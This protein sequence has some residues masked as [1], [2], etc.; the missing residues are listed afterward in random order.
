MRSWILIGLLLVACSS[1]TPA[2]V[3]TQV[4][5]ATPTTIMASTPTVQP[6]N[7][8]LVRRPNAYYEY[9]PST[10]SLARVSDTVAQPVARTI[11][12]A[13]VVA[14]HAHTML[15]IRTQDDTTI[16]V[17]ATTSQQFGPFDACDS[18]TWAPDNAALWCMRFGHIYQIDP[19]AQTD[20]LHIVAT[21]DTY[22]VAL[23]QHPLTN[24]HWMS[25]VRNATTQLCRFDAPHQT[26]T[27]GCIDTG[28]LPRWSPDGQLIASIVDRRIVITD[29]N[30]QHIASAGLGDIG[31]IQITW[32]DDTQLALN[33]RTQR[34]RYQINDARISV[35][36]SETIIVG[37]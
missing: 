17:D 3:D 8:P 19:A 37:R 4:E 21:G 27:T 7:A 15:A 1:S 26:A 31:V 32:I 30:S 10:Q 28:Y 35:Q 20:Q 2:P 5:R 11:P 33:S 29:T 22:W 18:M 13:M 25:L 16:I 14:N 36:A 9:S 24:A 23:T 12:V 6:T 34:Y